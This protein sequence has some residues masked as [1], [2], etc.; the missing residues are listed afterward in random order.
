MLDENLLRSIVADDADI[1][2]IIK[3]ADPAAMATVIRLIM[4]AGTSKRAELQ[5]MLVCAEECGLELDTDEEFNS[6]LDAAL[7]AMAGERRDQYEYLHMMHIHFYKGASYETYIKAIKVVNTMIYHVTNKALDDVK[8][9]FFQIG[10]DFIKKVNIELDVH[11]SSV[12]EVWD[13]LKNNFP[14]EIRR[15]RIEKYLKLFLT[16]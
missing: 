15:D 9:P 16:Y 3:N 12:L 10:A 13:T 2:G 1:E 4:N 8:K 11:G 7:P 14:D 5:R 6:T